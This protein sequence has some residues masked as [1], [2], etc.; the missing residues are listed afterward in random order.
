MKEC[1]I[2]LLFKKLTINDFLLKKNTSHFSLSSYYKST[3]VTEL[4]VLLAFSRNIHLKGNEN[5]VD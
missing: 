2:T 4:T 3:D 5:D 1:Q